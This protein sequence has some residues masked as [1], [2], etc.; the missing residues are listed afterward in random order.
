MIH[1]QNRIYLAHHCP[2]NQSVSNKLGLCL[3]R[4]LLLSPPNTGERWGCVW[5]NDGGVLGAAPRRPEPPCSGI[6]I[7]GAPTGRT[8]CLGGRSSSQRELVAERRKNPAWKSPATPQ[9]A[10]C[11]RKTGAGKSFLLPVGNSSA[12][13]DPPGSCTGCHQRLD[14]LF[15][16]ALGDCRGVGAVPRAERPQSI[17]GRDPGGSKRRGK[18]ITEQGC[19]CSSR[20]ESLER[21]PL[22]P[23]PSAKRGEMG[24]Q[25]FGERGIFLFGF[26]RFQI[27]LDY[28]HCSKT[29]FRKELCARNK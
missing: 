22:P 2:P 17:L 24:T 25:G 1:I 12:S 10:L 21:A 5:W 11:S 23:R 14:S 28:C 26:S 4:S 19:G 18:G 29:Q 15:G 20:A 8:G 16:Q 13:W 3:S 7:P 9:P 6:A 27:I